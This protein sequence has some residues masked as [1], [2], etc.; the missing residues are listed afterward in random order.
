MPAARQASRSSPNAFAVSATIG[1]RGAPCAA[2]WA[3]IRRVASRPSI[4]G[5]FT[6]IRMQSNGVALAAAR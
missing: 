2:S 5:M 3:R 1:V 6:S 4:S